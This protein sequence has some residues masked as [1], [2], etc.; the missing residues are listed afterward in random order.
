MSPE[1]LE[2]EGGSTSRDYSRRFSK[3]LGIRRRMKSIKVIPAD[4][5][6]VLVTNN[7]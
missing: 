1:K 6:D 2:E 7:I 5:D 3:L 4:N